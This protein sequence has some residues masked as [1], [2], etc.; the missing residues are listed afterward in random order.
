M[1]DTF[2]VLGQ[3]PG[4][5]FQITFYDMLAIVMLVLAARLYL[6][7]RNTKISELIKVKAVKTNKSKKSKKN[8]KIIRHTAADY[9]VKIKN[10][11]IIRP[12]SKR[13]V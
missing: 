7:N 8:P 2:L 13:P 4:T 12:H 9:L 5:R 1:W 3:V 10:L 6:K 11:P